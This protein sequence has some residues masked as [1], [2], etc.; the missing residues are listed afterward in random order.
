MVD[1]GGEFP[2]ELINEV[3]CALDPVLDVDPEVSE[4]RVGLGELGEGDRLANAVISPGSPN[5]DEDG[6]PSELLEGHSISL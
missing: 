6:G 4:F 1:D 3:A 2:P 5:V